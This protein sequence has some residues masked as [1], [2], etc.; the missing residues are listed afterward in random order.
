MKT[1][2]SITLASSVLKGI[3]MQS[4]E[5]K[6]RSQFIGIAVQRFLT[7]LERRETEQRDLEIIN[8]NADALNEEAEDVLRYQVPI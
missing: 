5:F 1:K 4:G 7:H 6:S 8:Q 2:T 3:A